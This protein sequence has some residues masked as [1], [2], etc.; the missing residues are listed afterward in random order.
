MSK[1]ENIKSRTESSS[2]EAGKTSLS[3]S[4]SV[5]NVQLESA[6]ETVKDEDSP[7]R[8]FRAIKPRLLANMANKGSGPPKSTSSRKSSGQ[9]SKRGSTQ[10]QPTDEGASSSAVEAE[11]V[12]QA[13]QATPTIGA[14][15]DTS[16]ADLTALENEKLRNRLE[17]I[18][19]KNKQLEEEKEKISQDRD[20]SMKNI[21]SLLSQNRELTAE[22]TTMKEQ[23]QRD[24]RMIDELQKQT[25]SQEQRIQKLKDENRMLNESSL[26]AMR[27][28]QTVSQEK[29]DLSKSY[30]T[31]HAELKKLIADKQKDSVRLDQA[32][33]RYTKL[34]ADYQTATKQIEQLR[35]EIKRYKDSMEELKAEN[36]R[37][38]MSSTAIATRDDVPVAKTKIGSSRGAAKK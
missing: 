16:K 33:Q 7:Q 15:E 19:R 18:L 27:E 12:K 10:V 30:K 20:E 34:K 14:A 35:A 21:E 32:E 23:R 38:K 29:S 1:K 5:Q 36:K 28:L 26:K 3:R 11:A 25:S 6:S 24:S 13:P 9:Q 37:L 4:G 31:Q 17:F 22:N 8:S 2:E